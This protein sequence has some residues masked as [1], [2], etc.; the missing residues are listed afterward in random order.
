MRS[1][2]EEIS[3]KIS[4]GLILKVLV[5][6]IWLISFLVFHF[7]FSYQ[8]ILID[9]T[10]Q[11]NRLQTDSI[12]GGNS[13]C[14]SYKIKDTIIFEY[15]LKY[16][17]NTYS[18]A[19]YTIEFNNVIDVS[20]YDNLQY[21]LRGDHPNILT[22]SAI[23]EYPNDTIYPLRFLNCVKEYGKTYYTHHIPLRQFDYSEFWMRYNG[24]HEVDLGDKNLHYL[25][26][27]VFE[28]G[29]N[30]EYD[31]LE[32]IEFHSLKFTKTLSWP[33]YLFASSLLFIF[34]YWSLIRKE[35]NKPEI[36]SLNYIAVKE[37]QGNESSPAII[38]LTKKYMYSNLT[39]SV[40]CE[41]LGIS[42][43]Q[44][45]S[46][47]KKLSSLTFKPFLNQ[48]RIE[49][50]KRLLIDTN[51]R[52]SEISEK[53]GYENV[54]HFNRVFKTATSKTPSAFKKTHLKS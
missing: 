32:K 49:E 39:T 22:L 4:R 2:L 19:N 5:L 34:T 25:K 28:S 15:T 6:L 40:V 41:E 46:E 29:L 48:I 13:N 30:P 35:M 42:E 23:L 31:R 47:I 38:Y 43:E 33:Y 9:K 16:T 52:V 37:L 7:K 18:Q 10:P 17:K 24:I 26:S 45:N 36:V 12:Y 11:T 54:T 21:T 44:L 20:N 27:V 8:E 1:K 3:I 53:V 14:K 51:A 50:A